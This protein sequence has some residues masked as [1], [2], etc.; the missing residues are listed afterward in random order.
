MSEPDAEWQRE[1][2]RLR[3]L[4]KLYNDID[5]DQLKYIG[6]VDLSFPL[7][8]NEHA[9]ACLVVLDYPSM[10]L[11]HSSFKQVVLTLPYIPGY[12]AFREVEPLLALLNDLKAA[13]PDI[14]PQ[15]ILVDGN[16]VLHPRQFG[17]ACHLGVLSDTPCIGIAKNFLHIPQEG[18]AMEMADVKSRCKNALQKRGDTV[19]LVGSSGFK[20]GAALRASDSAKNPVFVSQGH[21]IDLPTAIHVVLTCSKFKN[22]E[23]IRMADGLSR[24]YIRDHYPPR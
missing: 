19:D 23:P 8:D 17:L 5:I 9:V 14:Y 16:G 3:S 15:V 24:Q 7:N 12:L 10:T 20:Y 1:Q 6:G 2:E 22:A 13:S 4:V 21:R 11:V 18:T